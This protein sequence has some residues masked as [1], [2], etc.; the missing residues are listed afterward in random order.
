MSRTAMTPRQS[1]QPHLSG[2]FIDC[3][4]SR[5]GQ[6]VIATHSALYA[7]T[8]DVQSKASASSVRAEAVGPQVP[9]ALSPAPM[10]F[11]DALKRQQFLCQWQMAFE[12]A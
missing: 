2:H 11:L 8:P 9:I 12:L 6:E 5:D 10:V 4:L 1:P 7:I 3:L